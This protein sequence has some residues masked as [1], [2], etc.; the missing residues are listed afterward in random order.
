MEKSA[1]SEVKGKK[2]IRRWLKENIF[3]SYYVTWKPKR[4]EDSFFFPRYEFQ[5]VLQFSLSARGAV[6]RRGKA[7]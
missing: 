4:A 5:S 2:N 6:F 3:T 1:P 7:F